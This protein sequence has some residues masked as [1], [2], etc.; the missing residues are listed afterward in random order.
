MQQIS[1]VSE[2]KG[3]AAELLDNVRAS[4]GAT[5]NIFTTMANAPAALEGFLS[6]SG[7]LAKGVLSG[8][9]REAIALT[10][11]GANGCHYCA[12]AHTF[13]GGKSGVASDELHR[14]LCGQSDD[15]KT[16]TALNF[17][18]SIV[19][20]Q[21]RPSSQELIAMREAGF[22]DEELIE[23]LSHVALN[24]FTNYFNESFAVAVDFPPVDL[25]D[26]VRI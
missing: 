18:L 5:P 24:I 22:S 12:A 9:L 2:P 21:G 10:L 23:V 3:K 17:A 7:A 1:I 20:S 8:E 11:A 13:I 19:K 6:F 16:Q 25:P 15:P 26:D 4:L 14:N